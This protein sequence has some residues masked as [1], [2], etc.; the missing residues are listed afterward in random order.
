MAVTV[1]VADGSLFPGHVGW[2]KIFYERGVVAVWARQLECSHGQAG[3]TTD[4]RMGCL[5]E[6]TQPSL[7]L[8]PRK[9]RS[10]RDG[11]G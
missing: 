10:F 6:V 11:F 2:G 9:V 1:V 7:L 5:V 3:S 8:L 4:P